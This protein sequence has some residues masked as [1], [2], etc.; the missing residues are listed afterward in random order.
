MSKYL[1]LSS[2]IDVEP[3]VSHVLN[4]VDDADLQDEFWQRLDV[5]FFKEFVE[6]Y[7]RPDEVEM[8]KRII[9]DKYLGISE[10]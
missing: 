3:E 9:D 4:L 1:D 6:D 2:V 10:D 8:M 5:E 7:C